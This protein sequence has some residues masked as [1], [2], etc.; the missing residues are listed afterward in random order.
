MRP[1]KRNCGALKSTLSREHT[2]TNK[3]GHLIRLSIRPYLSAPRLSVVRIMPCRI[4]IIPFP[5]LFY[6]AP[7]RLLLRN[8]KFYNKE[9]SD[10]LMNLAP[11]V[12]KTRRNYIL[13]LIGTGF[14]FPNYC[15]RSVAPEL[16][17]FYRALYL[18]VYLSIETAQ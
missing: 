5:F 1:E 9:R 6:V 14:L 15:T 7:N 12:F 11:N 10:R 2:M 17:R 3:I 4:D 8:I 18:L 16:F 13:Y